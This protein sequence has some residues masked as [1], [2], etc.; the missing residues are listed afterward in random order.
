AR[1][2]NQGK[3]HWPGIRHGCE[4]ALDAEQLQ[5]LVLGLPWQRVGANGAITL[6]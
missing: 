6:L 3:F 4:I 2:L 1:R 5:A